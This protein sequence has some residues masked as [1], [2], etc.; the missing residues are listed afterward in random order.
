EAS[1]LPLSY[2]RAPLFSGSLATG[3]ST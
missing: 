1:A 3:A 2:A